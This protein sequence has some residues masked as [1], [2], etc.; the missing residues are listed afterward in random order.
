MF[1]LP[2][3]KNNLLEVI[4]NALRKEKT[5]EGHPY[6]KDG[7]KII[8]LRDDMK[9]QPRNYWKNYQGKDQATRRSISMFSKRASY[10]C[11]NSKLQIHLS[12]LH[13]D[14]GAE[15]CKHLF[16]VSFYNV[17]LCQ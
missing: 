1:V 12:T 8:L 3:L 14:N 17:S 2:T 13:G 6:Q 9:K 16:F 10:Q 11:I 5:S 4:S 15:S 7:S